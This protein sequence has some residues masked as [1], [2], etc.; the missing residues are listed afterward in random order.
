[1]VLVRVRV[2]VQAELG[3]LLIGTGRSVP[4]RLTRVDFAVYPTDLSY[5]VDTAARTFAAAFLDSVVVLGRRRDGGGVRCC[6]MHPAR[7]SPPPDGR[8]SP[9]LPT[10]SHTGAGGPG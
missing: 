7:P 8:V 5:S 3:Y 1:M 6:P 10:L 4:A 2:L 9:L